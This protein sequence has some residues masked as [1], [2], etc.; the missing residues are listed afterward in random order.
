M[1]SARSL[2]QNELESCRCIG[3]VEIAWINQKSRDVCYYEEVSQS[4]KCRQIFNNHGFI[5]PSQNREKEDSSDLLAITIPQESKFRR[6]MPNIS[7]LF[8]S[9]PGHLELNQI[10]SSIACA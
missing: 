4:Y 6:I 3:L 2:I 1:P 5:P 10:S 8:S 7:I 9:L